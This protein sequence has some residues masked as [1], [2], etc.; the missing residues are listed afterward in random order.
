MKF[1]FVFAAT[2]AAM[3]AAPAMAQ[4][5]GTIASVTVAPACAPVTAEAVN[6]QFDRFN[7]AWQ[8]RDPDTVTALF[9]ANATLLP[10]VSGRMRTD[11]AGIRDYFVTFLQGRPFGTITDSETTLG[12]N[13][14]TRAGNWTV[15]L[16]N[17]ETGAVNDVSARFTFI[18]TYEGGDWKIHHLH[19]S[20]RPAN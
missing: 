4:S 7:S 18:Y 6:S 13:I 8:T 1:A 20:A 11:T 2:S 12:C 5:D 19:S 9:G 3:L 14:A 10:T 16:T 15:R 17:A